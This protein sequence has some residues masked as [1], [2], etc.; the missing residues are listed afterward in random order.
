MASVVSDSVWLHRRQPTRLPR[1]WDS[2]GKNSGVGCHFLL[3]R[4]KVKSESEVTQPCPTLSNPMDCSLPGSSVHG[5]SR[6]EYWSR[7]PLPSLWPHRGSPKFCSCMLQTVGFWF[8]L[9][10]R[11]YESIISFSNTLGYYLGDST[12]LFINFPLSKFC[13][14]P[15]MKLSPEK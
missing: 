10:S 6:Q 14:I 3:Q 12:I 9:V 5:F 4:M 7:V 13:L 2:P 15:E 8:W 11:P 1:P